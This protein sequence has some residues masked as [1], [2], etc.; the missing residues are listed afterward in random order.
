[1][2]RLFDGRE[3]RSGAEPLRDH[4]RRLGPLPRLDGLF[5]EGLVQ[6]GLEGRGGAG[7]PTGL[8]W[9]AVASRSRGQAVIVVNGAEGEPQSK[10]DRALMTVRPH[11]ILDGA[12]IAARA[13]RARQ[14]V[15]Y[16]GDDKPGARATIAAAL[17]ERPEGERAITTIVSGPARYVAGESSAV[18]H[19]LGEGVATPTTTPPGAHERGVGGSPT[20]VQ[21]VETLA[22]VALIARGQAAH[23]A[24]LT[25]AGGVN[26]PGVV[27]LERSSTI[28]D[29]I[30]RA[31]GLSEPARALLIG[32]Y[33]GR[34]IELEVAWN[35]KLDG[36]SLQAAGLSLGCGVIG[37]LAQS[38]C[39]VC[40]TSGIMH[41]LASESSAQCGPCFFGLRA[42]SAACSR[43]AHQ[44]TNVDDL[45]H[46]ERWAGEVRGRGACRHPDGAVMF[47][48]SALRVFAPEFA[49]HVHH[50]AR[51]TA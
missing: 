18:V 43:I 29:A 4:V 36:R 7:F 27:E 19:L 12:F 28:G 32:G 5:I 1:M 6:S 22:H 24:L 20:L 17:A 42:L 34:W 21:N 2:T 8:K 9:R 15:V 45:R 41:Y 11:L 10:K 48:E 38:R 25:V 35:V 40:E 47:L 3:L 37:V 44:G 46:L 16:I 26:G 33:F 23:T 51:R 14:I 31:G 39:P 50:T 49:H 13:L 30:A